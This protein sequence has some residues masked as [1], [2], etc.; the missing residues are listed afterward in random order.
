VPRTASAPV[1]PLDSG[2]LDVGDGQ[3]IYWETV[4]RADGLPAVWLHGG[5][6][7]G[8]STT[9]R[10]YFDPAVYRAV[11]L[12]QRGCGRSRP[13]AGEPSVD[14]TTNT[15]GHLM[16][17]LERLRE[18][19]EIERWVVAGVSWGVTLALAYA[20]RHPERVTG[21]VLGAVTTGSRREVEWLT[22]DMGRLLPEQWD[23]FVSLVSPDER[24]GDLTAAYG[25]LL[26]HR[27]LEVRQEAAQAWCTWEDAHV[28]LAPGWKPDPRYDDPTFRLVF[29][30][31]VTHYWSHACFLADRQLLAGMERLAA[32]P[33]VLIHGRYDISSPPDTAWR[34]H[35]AWP[36]SRLV[37]LD[38]SHGG[39]GF[40]EAITEALDTLALIESSR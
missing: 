31:L 19:L 35:Q 7:S 28:S 9:A 36:G 33:G 26:A 25:R 8:S 32:V 15:T 14:L 5:P 3:S 20:Q 37:L 38:A 21:L 40:A 6:G 1:D 27:D 18:H 24:N 34:L 39:P 16:D 17:D 4:G 10:R 23:R 12:D 2:S 30:R 22:R 13:L 11:L 29:A